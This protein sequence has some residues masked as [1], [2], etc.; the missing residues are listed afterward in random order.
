MTIAAISM[1][2]AKY[3][4]D[5]EELC[6]WAVS[7][8]YHHREGSQNEAQG[9][10]DGVAGRDLLMVGI[11]PNRAAYLFLAS[12]KFSDVE[13]CRRFKLLKVEIEVVEIFQA[14]APFSHV[15][16]ELFRVVFWGGNL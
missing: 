10:F 8:S 1:A 11:A 16:H 12:I 13:A 7:L 4:D 2:M 3:I 14:G 9:Q 15:D 6:S 5:L